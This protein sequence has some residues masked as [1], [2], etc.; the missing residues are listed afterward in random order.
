[1]HYKDDPTIMAW[2]LMNEPRCTSDPSGRTI[3]A[4]I[5]EM[6]SHVKSIDRNHLLE[7]GLEGFYGQSTPQKKRLN[8]S[9]DIGTDF[10]ANNQIPGIDFA[11]V[12]SYPDQWLSS[13]S[14]Q[15]QLSFLNNWLDAHIRDARIILRK[16]ILLAEFG[17]SWKDPGFNTYQ[18]DRLFN[19]VYNKIYWSAKT[20][21]PASGGLFWQLLAR[22]ME[23][24]RDGYEIILSERSSTANVIA[25]QS[26]KLDQ[27]RKIF[28]RRRNVQRW[29]RARAKRRGGWHGLWK[30]V[31]S[32]SDEWFV[33]PGDYGLSS[34]IGPSIPQ[35]TLQALLGHACFATSS[36]RN[37]VST[38]RA[39]NLRK[40]CTVPNIAFIGNK[41]ILVSQTT[42]INSFRKQHVPNAINMLELNSLLKNL[43]KTGDLHEARQM[44]DV[45]PQ[46]DEISWTIIISGYVRA[47]KSSEALPLFSKMWVSPGLSMD[48]FC[49]S[50]ALKACALEFN[51]NYGELLHGYLVKS[52]FINSVFAGSALLDMY[53]KFGKIEL[54]IKV[55]DEMPIKSVVSWTAIITGL[56]HGEYYKK[57]LVYLSEMRKS[58]VEYDSYTLAIVLKACACLGAL[59][60]G[61]EIHTHTVKRG[62]NDTSYVANSL[63]TMYNK[64]GKLDYGLR[65]FDKMNTRDVVSWTSIITTYVQ[66]RE[67]VNAIEAFTRMQEAGVSPNE[68][69]FAAVIAS[70]SGLVRISWGEQLHAHV[71][72]IGLADTLSVANSLMTMYSKCGQI[73]S[74]AMVFHGMSRRDTISWS[75]IIAVYSQGGYGEE[76]FEHLSWMRKEGPKPTQFAFASVLSVCG[77]MAILEQGRQLHAHV[78]SIGL[79]QE[80]MIQSA[81][82]NMYSK[83]GCIKDAEKVFN[84]AENYNIVTWTAMINGYADHGYIHETIN[85]FKMLSKVGLKPDSVTFIGLLTACSHAGLADLGFHY[86]NLMSS[87]YQIRPSKE[88]YGCMID[89]LCR[90]GRLTEAEEM[91]KSM[92]FHRDDVVWSTLLRACRVQGN[93]DCGERAAEKLLEMDPNCAGTHI[94]LANIYSAKGKWRE[95][96]DVRKMMRTKGVMKEPGWSWIKVKDRVSAFVAGERSYP[97][98]EEIYGMLD[99]LA[100]RVDISVQELGSLLDLED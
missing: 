38:I 27:I 19:I 20:G 26:H 24:F 93:V 56:V 77:N 61:R 25:Q 28:T 89:L 21:G 83:C 39:H 71:L 1:M 35:T 80:E 2:E 88:H 94:T 57:G 45:M 54:G 98:G 58:G 41:D 6:A 99:L 65:L 86:F 85:L 97:E 70:C 46:R 84:E 48:P 74:A 67:D 72:R 5:M 92:P 62:F 18:R 82:V 8:P 31:Y 11:T 64:C 15:Y 76:A 29:K 69:T 91:I 34:V 49:L 60:F 42:S 66:M 96:A 95:A 10:I 17:K 52:G 51:L 87:E 3:Q 43:V 22:G 12:H 75:T 53:A 14:E 44:F 23:S 4:W 73:S 33:P 30:R 13:S 47:M 50:I 9:L 36:D 68:F 16:P 55:F 63:S 78:L 40:L 32:L 7:A 100:S 79:E 81:L 59:N 90:A 37:M